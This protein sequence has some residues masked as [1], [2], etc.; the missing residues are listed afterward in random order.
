MSHH[1]LHVGGSGVNTAPQLVVKL[2]NLLTVRPADS[3]SVSI[4]SCVAC[5]VLV[6][7]LL[8]AAQ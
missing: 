7:F 3:S 1:V 8:I 2:D 5:A 4:A 6:H